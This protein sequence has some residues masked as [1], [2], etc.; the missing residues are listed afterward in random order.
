[1]SSDGK[2]RRHSVNIP[3]FL[4]SFGHAFR[5]GLFFSS[6]APGTFIGATIKTAT[7][8]AV[9]PDNKVARRARQIDPSAI[10]LFATG[11]P[12]DIF[13]RWLGLSVEVRV[14][15]NSNVTLVSSR[16]CKWTCFFRLWVLIV[17]GYLAIVKE[18]RQDRFIFIF[19][20]FD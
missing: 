18:G 9:V 17:G 20:Y 10:K 1:M 14:L 5:N 8:S 6:C 16:R 2:V 19:L 4:S 13:V 3:K 7:V 12:D 15:S 11:D